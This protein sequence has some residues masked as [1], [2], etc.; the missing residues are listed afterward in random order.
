MNNPRHSANSTIWGTPPYIIEPARLVLGSIDLD[1]A[2]S[3]RS[4]KIIKARDYFTKKQNG[5]TQRW[6]A[7]DLTRPTSIW[8]NPPGGWH[9]GEV[10]NSEV[11]QWWRKTLIERRQ[12]YFGHMLF[13]AFSMEALQVTQVM[14]EYS[15]C[16]FPTVIFNKRIGFIDPAT[17]K[18]VAGNT[19][20]S[21]ITY[22]PGRVRKTRLFFETFSALGAPMGPINWRNI[23]K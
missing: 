5:L 20:A 14:C 8:L 1:P 3:A 16:D 18:G 17:G 21:S 23:P 9:N 7:Y 2:S 19:H 10:G 13:L 11:K 12:P 22:I 4:N 6:Q 15:L